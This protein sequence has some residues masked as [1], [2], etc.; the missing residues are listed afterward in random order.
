MRSRIGAALLVFFLLAGATAWA[1][2]PAADKVFMWKVSVGPATVFLLGSLHMGRPEMYPLDQAITKAFARSARLVV[3]I[4]LLASHQRMRSLLARYTRYPPGQDLKGHISAQTLAKLKRFC[5]QSK[6]P[7]EPLLGFKPVR[8][9]Q[10]VVTR[11]MQKAGFSA[12]N[13]IDLFFLL[14]ANQRRLPVEELESPEMQMRLIYDL[15]PQIQEM[16]L[17]QA[18]EQGDRLGP[19]WRNIS[20]M[21]QKGDAAGVAR[22]LA[23]HRQQYPRLR[24]FYRRLFEERNRLMADRVFDYLTAPG[25]VFVV[26]GAGHLV[27][28]GSVLE[29]LAK[30]GLKPVQVKALGRPPRPPAPAKKKRQGRA[31]SRRRAA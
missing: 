23:K 7:L 14:R 28:K 21:W 25:R 11:E 6:I 17:L 27:G 8:L 31:P 30:R 2:P 13:G 12:L 18:L 4:N 5:M 1:Q 10:M 9:S 19:M 15:P 24:G 29:L 3:E 26:M 22:L 16:M 20:A